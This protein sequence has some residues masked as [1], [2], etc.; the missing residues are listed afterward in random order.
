[1]TAPFMIAHVTSVVL[2]WVL[3]E[4]AEI[5]QNVAGIKISTN[6]GLLLN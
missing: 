5:A 6:N 1:M 4:A 3:D 2:L